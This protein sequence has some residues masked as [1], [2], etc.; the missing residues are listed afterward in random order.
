MDG[1]AKFQIESSP[2]GRG[3][4]KVNGEDVT[5]QISGMTFDMRPGQPPLLTLHY[6]GASGVIEGEGIVR[7]QTEPTEGDDLLEFLE[8]INPK[9]LEE[10]ALEQS[11]WG[12]NQTEMMLTILKKWAA[13][14]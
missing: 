2:T 12:D 14:A 9:L 1:L 4:V 3:T 5:E 7:V 11:G 13:G 8:A 6:I 10:E